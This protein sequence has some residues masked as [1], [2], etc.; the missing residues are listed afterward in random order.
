MPALYQS[1][2][3]DKLLPVSKI[4]INKEKARLQTVI[5]QECIAVRSGPQTL[6]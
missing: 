3:K 5:N 4:N 2:Q 1:S 6:T